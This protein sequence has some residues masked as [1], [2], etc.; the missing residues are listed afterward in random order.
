MKQPKFLRPFCDCMIRY[1]TQIE[2]LVGQSVR[3]CWTLRPKIL[4]FTV[5][6][7]TRTHLN[8]WLRPPIPWYHDLSFSAA[9][10][11]KSS[12][13]IILHSKI[14]RKCGFWKN[15]TERVNR[16]WIDQL[17]IDSENMVLEDRVA[18]KS[19]NKHC[20]NRLWIRWMDQEKLTSKLKA[21][22]WMP[23]KWL[24]NMV[25]KQAHIESE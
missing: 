22:E 13:W 2:P 4:S 20:L 8:D 7:Y 24:L 16:W 11:P 14:Y 10:F 23:N 12:T 9:C 3:L 6:H 25:N 21:D 1:K 18:E 19:V 15:N 5:T 17:P